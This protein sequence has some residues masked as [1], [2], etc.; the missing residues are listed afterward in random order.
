[1]R[2]IEAAGYRAFRTAGS[3]GEFD[4]IGVGEHGFLLVQCK[5]NVKPS[6]AEREAMELFPTPP[7]AVKL[8][9]YYVKGK[10]EPL[11][12]NVKNGVQ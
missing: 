1:M 5:Y 8:I 4:V 7:N 2:L 3:H 10:R 11:V 12:L 6:P 9:H